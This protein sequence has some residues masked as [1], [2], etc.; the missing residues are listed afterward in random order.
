MTKPLR[1]LLLS[2]AVAC[3]AL[4]GATHALAG[5][6]SDGY[7]RT[8]IGASSNA[9]GISARIAQ[10]Y[11]PDILSGHVAGWVGVG[12]RGQGHYGSNEWLRVGSATYPGLTGDIFYEVALPGRSPT[13]HQVSTGVALGAYT[14]LTVL[15]MHNRPNLWRV[16]VNHKPVSPPI[17]LPMSHDGLTATAKSECWAG[18]AGG[19]C[20]DFP[21]SFRDVSIARA[22][23]AD[24]QRLWTAGPSRAA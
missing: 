14:K 4:G 3:V 22:P 11:A 12:G 8:T 2:A 18:G 1:L 23:G 5:G 15:E 24:W 13:Y 6:D 20:N 10:L 17:R 16:W 19:V 9:Y 21:Y 7:S